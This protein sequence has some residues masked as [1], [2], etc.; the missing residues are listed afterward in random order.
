M[1]I[2]HDN[3]HH[4]LN[5]YNHCMEAYEETCCHSIDSDVCVAALWHDIGKPYV[6]AF[7]GYN[8][9]TCEIAHYYQHQCL[10]AWLVY[11]FEY[12]TPYIAWL[13]ST[14]MDPFLNTKYY[15]NLPDFLKKDIDVLHQADLEAH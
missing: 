11:G 13:I 10:G 3:P 15:K 7:V 2:P 8:G 5:I 6:K 4:T 9:N 12:V 14:H 1:R